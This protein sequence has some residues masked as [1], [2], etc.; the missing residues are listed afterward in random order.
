MP[1][2]AVTHAY[3]FY[4]SLDVGP[5]HLLMTDTETAF[6]TADIDIDDAQKGWIQADLATVDKS[7]SA[8]PIIMAAGHRPLYILY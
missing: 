8:T 5:L 2:D 4:Y 6:D 1:N 3:G 7:A